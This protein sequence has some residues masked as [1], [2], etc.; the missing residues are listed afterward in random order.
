MKEI[1]KTRVIK[2][3]MIGLITI[4]CVALNDIQ[5]IDNES[6]KINE[7]TTIKVNEMNHQVISLK[8]FKNNFNKFS[9]IDSKVYND[10]YIL[11]LNNNVTV[12]YKVNDD[13]FYIND[14]GNIEEFEAIE[15]TQ[16]YLNELLK[17]KYNDYKES[18][19]NEYGEEGYLLMNQEAGISSEEESLNHYIKYGI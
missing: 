19:I 13:M 18:L 10:F 4:G 11:T 2:V 17:D 8:E 15:D 5:L 6:N 1:F 16:R 12:Y 3:I 9:V 7:Y 14:S